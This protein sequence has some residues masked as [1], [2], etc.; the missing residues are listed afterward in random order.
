MNADLSQIRRTAAAVLAEIRTVHPVVLSLTNS[1]AQQITANML[2]A[3]G[4]APVMLKD[5]SEVENLMD[6]GCG[7]MLLNLGTLSA[8]QA[9]HMLDAV[10][11]A[12][13]RGV[14]W[15]LDPVA[16]GSLEFRTALCRDLL[17]SYPSIIRGNASEILALAG[18]APSARGTDA[19]VSSADAVQ[20]AQELAAETRA[21]V[22]VTG[23]VDYVTDG[24]ALHAIRSGHPLMTRVAGVG[25]GLGALCAACL[26]CAPSAVEAA[27]AASCILGDAGLR[28]ARRADTVGSFA[29][30]LLDELDRPSTG[31]AGTK[32]PRQQARL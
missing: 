30:A 1:V 32:K 21:V 20:P 9:V 2:L 17:K 23:E 10:K 15:V 22:L 12:H 19:T 29:T 11:A 6:A 3:V 25:C 26:A 18:Y 4:A 13:E 5:R 7:G 16:V 8:G 27:V 24:T 14:P 28:A 31:N